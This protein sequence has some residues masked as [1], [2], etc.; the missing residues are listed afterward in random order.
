MKTKYSQKNMLELDISVFEQTPYLGLVEHGMGCVRT[1]LDV[2]AQLYLFFVR[3][4]PSWMYLKKSI[5]RSNT[6]KANLTCIKDYFLNS[7]GATSGIL[8]TYCGPML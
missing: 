8:K 1:V 2:L 5:F 3:T 4:N 6:I 7:A